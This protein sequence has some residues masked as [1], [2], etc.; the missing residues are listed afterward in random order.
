MIKCLSLD[1][2]HPLYFICKLLAEVECLK[3]PQLKPVKAQTFVQRVL[4][5]LNPMGQVIL[6]QMFLNEVV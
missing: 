6:K 2:M 3:F 5:K 1:T 4:S